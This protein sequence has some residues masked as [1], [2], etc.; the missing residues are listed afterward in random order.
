MGEAVRV[1][2]VAEEAEPTVLGALMLEGA[3]LDECFTLLQPEDFADRKH[4][5]IYDVMRSLYSRGVELDPI[6]VTEEL[7]A[8]K[9]L[10]RC[11]GTPYIAELL[12]CT[13]TAANLLYHARLVRDRS[14]RRR[15]HQAGID[16][17]TVAQD[18]TG[19]DVAELLDEAE[20]K[21]LDL[22]HAGTTKQPQP[23]KSLLYPAFQRMEEG[24]AKGVPTPFT[25]L[26]GLLTGDGFLPGQL[27]CV[28]GATSM[29]KTSMGL[30][31]ALEAAKEKH[32]TL[33]C[34]I[35]MTKDENVARMLSLAS[36]VSLK[37]IYGGKDALTEQDMERLAN[38][39]GWLHTLPLVLE[40]SAM[41]LLA[42]RSAARRTKALYGLRVLV[43]DHIH[44]M[45]DPAE[46]RRQQLG[47]IARGLK[48]LA[49]ELDVT[50]LALAQ[51]SRKPEERTD[52]KPR[53]SDLRESGDIEAACDTILLL[54]RPE[55]YFGPTMQ[56]GKE[57]RDVQGKAECIIAK[58]R[59]GALGS[60]DLYF[61]KECA[62]FEQVA[63]SWGNR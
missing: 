38:D 22:A 41:T 60:V 24:R 31:L 48:H 21:V 26:N 35:E 8:Q 58:Q 5:A 44:D 50:V 42:I 32:P 56:V 6:A 40:D 43:V 20:R 47:N 57:S 61:R 18:Q 16:I 45:A 23:L 28:A 46:E 25:D 59:N 7:R 3:A 19:R 53:L 30:Q 14:L 51:L 2:P 36:G 27:V 11:G 29:G 17:A 54:Y 34:S 37:R 1:L 10:E 12:E 39:A 55:Y 9:Q 13:P 62:A 52:H 33:V 15:L 4:R 63:Q 49:K